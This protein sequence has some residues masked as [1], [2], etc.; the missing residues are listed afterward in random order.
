MIMHPAIALI[1]FGLGPR[2]D[3][4]LPPDSR[5]WLLAQLDGPGAAAYPTGLLDTAGALAAGRQRIEMRKETKNKIP[6]DQDPVAQADEADQRAEAMIWVGAE[7]S[8][9]ERMVLFWANHFTT[10]RRNGGTAALLGPFVREAIRPNI[11][12]NFP[13]LLLAVMR[14]PAMLAY[15][16]NENSVGPNSPRGLKT[17]E[18]LNENLARECMEL[19]TVSPASGY[20]QQ[21]VTAMAR[22]LTGWSVKRDGADAG[23]LYRRFAHEPGAH[24]VLQQRFA[25][26]E[27][28]GIDALR[29]LA[30]HPA[31]AQH[32]SF[33]LARHFVSDTPPPALVSAMTTRYRDTGGNLPAVMGV[34]IDFP[35]AWPQPGQ[36]VRKLRTPVEY[37]AASHRALGFDASQAPR[38]VNQT[39]G[40]EQPIW[41]APSPKGWSDVASDWLD[42]AMLLKRVEFAYVNAAVG[43]PKADVAAL[44]ALALGPYASPATAKAVSSAGSRPEAVALLLSSPEFWRR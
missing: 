22:I 35:G 17:H 6:K 15:L 32:V 40:L 44:P 8:F 28:G 10:S 21:D 30:L 31:T 23:F 34:L 24:V 36:G 43:A 4:N 14:H 26:G 37:V 3:Q 18:G 33:K 19:H 25:E 41:G 16:N 12:G 2:P 20:T 13:D 27:Q 38:L 42:P 9:R 29:F 1:H 39:R 7:D 11:N 5:A